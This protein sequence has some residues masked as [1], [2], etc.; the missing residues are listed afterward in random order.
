MGGPCGG[1]YLADPGGL[2]LGQRIGGDGLDL[3]DNQVRPFA[4]DQLAQRLRVG[5]VH[6]VRAVCHL[7][8]GR[9]RIAVHGDHLDAET[10]QRDDDLF[11]QFAGTEQ[12]NSRSG[13]A[14]WG[15]DAH[16]LFLDY[17]R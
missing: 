14:E 12:H 11:A 2:D 6:H 3:R 10:L 4:L 16:N 1:D 5:H 8:A 7:M 17:T 9:I 13:R 15:S